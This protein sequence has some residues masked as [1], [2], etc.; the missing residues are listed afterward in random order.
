M[1]I[2]TLP[3]FVRAM[4]G[5]LVITVVFPEGEV[6]IDQFKKVREEKQPQKMA[7]VRQRVI[8]QFS[9]KNPQRQTIVESHP[10]K[11]EGWGTRHN[12]R[13]LLHAHCP[14]SSAR[15]RFGF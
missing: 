3:D 5:Q 6:Q 14:G 13:K 12:H 7:S 15:P 9:R 4:G 1:Y 11:T 8:S 2:S 10:S